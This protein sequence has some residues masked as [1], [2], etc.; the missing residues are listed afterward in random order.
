VQV[1]EK[2][3]A[4]AQDNTGLLPE[5]FHAIAH[6]MKGKRQQIQQDKQLRQM[7]FAMPE[8]VLQMIAVVL[9]HIEALVFDLPAGARASRNF[10]HVVRCH[11][12]TGHESAIVG[13]FSLGIDDADPEPVDGQRVFSVAQ[14]NALDPAVV[15]DQAMLAGPAFGHRVLVQRRALDK[16][17]QRLVTVFFAHEQE[18]R[19]GGEHRFGQRLATEQRIAQIDRAQLAHAPAVPFKVFHAAVLPYL[20]QSVLEARLEQFG[21]RRIE[22]IANVIVAGN[23][24]DAKQRLAVGGVAAMFHA[25]LMR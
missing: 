20:L 7:L 19:A 1:G 13:R 25:P 14:R 24:L 10:D 22:Q 9:Q 6:R 16:L 8:V 5:L 2:A 17:V 4:G 21:R 15:I 3:F 12:Q 18:V 11:R 23:L